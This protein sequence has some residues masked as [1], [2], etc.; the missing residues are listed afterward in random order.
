MPSGLAFSSYSSLLLF[1]SPLS[2][3]CP[4]IIGLHNTCTIPS[5][6]SLFT[7]GAQQICREACGLPVSVR[8]RRFMLLHLNHPS[9]SSFL[10]S[11]HLC[12][13]CFHPH[14]PLP[15]SDLQTRDPTSGVVM[16]KK[17]T[18]DQIFYVCFSSPPKLVSLEADRS[19]LTLHEHY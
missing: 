15:S 3:H 2:Q 13:S 1:F 10:P 5:P 11:C 18:S 6:D 9:H 4:R 19:L 12:Q 8:T 16:A 14:P 17:K 7:G